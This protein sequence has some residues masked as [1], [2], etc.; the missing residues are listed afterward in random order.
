MTSPKP[1]SALRLA[2]L[3]LV[4]SSLALT[5]AG[6]QKKKK[7]PPPAPPPVKHVAEIPQPIDTAALLQTMKSDARVQFPSSVAPADRT[8]AEGVITLANCLAKGDSAGLKPI[9]ASPA[10]N[11]LDE[12]VSSGGWAE[13]TQPIE[14]VR[15]ISVSGTQEAQPSDSVVG[16]AI[17]GKDGAYLLA[18]NAH[19]DNSKWTFSNSPCQSDVKPRASDF[20]GVS[21]ATSVEVASAATSGAALGPTTKEGAKAGTAP[22]E[23]PKDPMRK[24][25]PAGPITIPTP[26][27]SR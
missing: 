1:E 17:Q 24:S 8:L 27:G 19:R 2:T 13:G 16:L 11:V 15:V 9:L 26:G 7:A 5:G 6:C 12:L 3:A 10:Q 20:D 18:W 21:L 4:A 22:A 23:K 14:Q 25:T